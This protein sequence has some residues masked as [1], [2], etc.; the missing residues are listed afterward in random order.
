MVTA[1]PGAVPDRSRKL[2]KVGSRAGL[3]ATCRGLETPLQ[4]QEL[5]AH[6]GRSAARRPERGLDLNPLPH[7]PTGDYR[8]RQGR[9]WKALLEELDTPLRRRRYV[10]DFY[11]HRLLASQYS[12]EEEDY[13][14]MTEPQ[15]ARVS[16]SAKISYAVWPALK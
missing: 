2:K 4:L 11:E 1:R 12:F 16:G 6:P 7:G 15:Q 3:L 5:L 13:D 14:F 8:I 9:D 10:R